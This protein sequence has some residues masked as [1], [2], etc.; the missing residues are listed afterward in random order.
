M[1]LEVNNSE[2]TAIQVTQS[3]GNRRTCLELYCDT[4]QAR[5][6][7]LE[8]IQAD[9]TAVQSGDTTTAGEGKTSVDK[10]E[11]FL[12][13]Q[14]SIS[15]NESR[16][17]ESGSQ[18][19]VLQSPGSKTEL[20]N[21]T[22]GLSGAQTSQMSGTASATKE[23]PSRACK[24]GKDPRLKLCANSDCTQKSVVRKRF[25]NKTGLYCEVGK[26]LPR[27]VLS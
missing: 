24:K 1:Q 18:S 17:M 16:R 19:A 26:L 27:R 13:Q 3:F 2:V 23:R 14:M 4:I 20:E 15:K 22:Q 7:S 11:G 12:S 10:Q 6:H 8:E 9:N 21:K 25:C 5:K